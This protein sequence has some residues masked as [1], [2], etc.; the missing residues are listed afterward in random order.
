MRKSLL[1]IFLFLTASLGFGQSFK[2]HLRGGINIS[3]I[4][5]DGLGGYNKLGF[6][7][8]AGVSFPDTGR[9]WRFRQ[10]LYYIQKGSRASG[11]DFGLGQRYRLHYLEA[12]LLADFRPFQQDLSLPFGVSIGYLLDASVSNSNVSVST[13]IFRN[14]DMNLIA[15]VGYE[16]LPKLWL[17]GRFSYSIYNIYKSSSNIIGTGIWRNNVL[18]F[19]LLY[20]L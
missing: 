13:D 15:G 16:L 17:E 3:Q 8:G 9:V 6:L 10:E 4:D 20:D 14:T 5:G 7:A 2:G 18:Q 11:K 19:S 1:I 12:A